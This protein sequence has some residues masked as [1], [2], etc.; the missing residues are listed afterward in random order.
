MEGF[1]LVTQ[2]GTQQQDYEPDV[3]MALT[4]A[5]PEH[6]TLFSALALHNTPKR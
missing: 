5:V 4:I 6:L 3:Y 2:P 1:V